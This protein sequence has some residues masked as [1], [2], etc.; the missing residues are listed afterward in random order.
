MKRRTPQAKLV[1][2]AVSSLGDGAYGYN[3]A[4]ETG[5]NSQTVYSVVGRFV[6]EGYLNEHVEII[7][8]RLRRRLTI[9]NEGINLLNKK[10]GD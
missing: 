4:K 6:R 2:Q 1:L 5:L 3:I 10:F 9:T 7:D 8:G